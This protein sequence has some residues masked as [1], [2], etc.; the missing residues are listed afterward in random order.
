MG[1]NKRETSI[2]LLNKLLEKAVVSE[3][4]PDTEGKGAGRNV[5]TKKKVSKPKINK[6]KPINT[7]IL[8][9]R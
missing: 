1:R 5:D 4:K 9:T 3:M 8:L 6:D 7:R 2:Q